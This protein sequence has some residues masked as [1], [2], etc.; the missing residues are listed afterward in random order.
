[1]FNKFLPGLMPYRIKDS[2]LF[3]SPVIERGVGCAIPDV[4]SIDGKPILK[5]VIIPQR[6]DITYDRYKTLC[7]AFVKMNLKKY[8]LE[9]VPIQEKQSFL[10]ILNDENIK[11]DWKEIPDFVDVVNAD[12]AISSRKARKIF[13]KIIMILDYIHEVANEYELGNITIQNG[14]LIRK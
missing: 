8:K 2:V 4:E 9:T 7:K 1:M 6:I 14:T 12:K 5:G 11:I 3:Q 10:I 13:V